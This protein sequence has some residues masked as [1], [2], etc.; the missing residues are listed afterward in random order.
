M[1][2]PARYYISLA[3]LCAAAVPALYFAIHVFFWLVATV[4]SF[5]AAHNDPISLAVMTGS[6]LY[7]LGFVVMTER[8][9][10]SD[11]GYLGTV[12]SLLMATFWPFYAALWL[13]TEGMRLTALRRRL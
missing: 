4:G 7:L 6:I 1:R 10:E 13:A 11:D 9:H 12:V 8:V 2:R 3:V 5:L